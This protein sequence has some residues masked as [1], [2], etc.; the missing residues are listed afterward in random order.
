M[1]ISSFLLEY[2]RLVTIETNHWHPGYMGAMGLELRANKSDLEFDEFH[3]L[4]R[5][6]LEID[7]LIIKKSDNRVLQNEIGAIFRQFNVTEYKSPGD[8]MNLSNYVKTVGYACI[9]NHNLGFYKLKIASED[10][11]RQNSIFGLNGY[12]SYFAPILSKNISSRLL[13]SVVQ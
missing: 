10:A 3:T 1:R 6:A 4:S 8:D 7:L 12:F 9:L 11:I 13:V 2:K 5:E